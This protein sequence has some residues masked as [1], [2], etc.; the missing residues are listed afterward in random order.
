MSFFSLFD[1]FLLVVWFCIY[2]HAQM[3]SWN[4]MIL[5]IWNQNIIVPVI[6]NSI[7][8][9]FNVLTFLCSVVTGKN[10][11]N[12][13]VVIHI[14]LEIVCQTRQSLYVWECQLQE[15]GIVCVVQ[16]TPAKGDCF[17]KGLPMKVHSVNHNFFYIVLLF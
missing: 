15:Y 17:G 5:C 6:G 9:P 4:F 3:K 2:A 1:S 12:S 16:Y 10:K 11:G 13:F 8:K 7:V 14:G